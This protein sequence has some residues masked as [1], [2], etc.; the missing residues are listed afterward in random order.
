MDEARVAA[1]LAEAEELRER[2]ELEPAF[3]GAGGGEIEQL[4]L[5]GFL[6]V[7]VEFGLRRREIAPDDL[8]DFFGKLGGDSGFSAA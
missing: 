5:G 3:A 8:F 4:A 6:G 7:A 2:G 1:D